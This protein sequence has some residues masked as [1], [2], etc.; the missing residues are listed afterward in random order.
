MTVSID[1]FFG[2]VTLFQFSALE[3]I[4][5]AANVL[6]FKWRKGFLGFTILYVDF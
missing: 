6:G 1:I 2:L 4:N 5:L 3:I